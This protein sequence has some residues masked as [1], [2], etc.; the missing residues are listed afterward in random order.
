NYS[1]CLGRRCRRRRRAFVV[2]GNGS[3]RCARERCARRRRA[4]SMKWRWFREKGKQK[5]ILTMAARV[6][7]RIVACRQ[8]FSVDVRELTALVAA[9]QTVR[10]A[11]SMHR[12]GEA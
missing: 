1:E 7:A 11:P 5:K 8:S 2:G 9:L 12:R 3:L 6:A 10:R 4:R